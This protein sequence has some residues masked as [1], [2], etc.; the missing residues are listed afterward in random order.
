MEGGGKKQLKVSH[1]L[2][3]GIGVTCL[4]ACSWEEASSLEGA[5]CQEEGE[6]L[7]PYQ[8]WEAGR[9]LQ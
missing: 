7:D 9:Q 2:P 6:C 4:E 5:S 3:C 1:T 8:V